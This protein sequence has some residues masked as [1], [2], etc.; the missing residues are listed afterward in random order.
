[1][2]YKSS[3]EQA[4][5]DFVLYA[6]DMIPADPV[7]GG[8]YI[9]RPS[10]QQ[11]TVKA[12]TASTIQHLGTFRKR[13]GFIGVSVVDG[14]IYTLSGTT[15]T[16]QVTTANLTTS[17]I[18]LSSTARVHCCSFNNTYVMNDGVNQPFTYDGTSGAASVV[19]LTNAPSKCF[20]KPTVYYG[21]LF[22]I[23]D[24]AASS[25]DRSKIVWSEEYAANT[26]YEAGGYLNV[27]TL[28]QAGSGALYAIVGTNPG[29]YYFRQDS[30]G[31]IH[32]AVTPAFTSSGVHEDVSAL[33]GTTCPDVLW[34]DR[35]IYFL[36]ARGR[37]WRFPETGTIEPLW[38]E[39]ADLYGGVDT[40]G[41]GVL[42]LGAYD[43]AKSNVTAFPW[44][45]GVVFGTW[46]TVDQPYN[47][48]FSHL[49]GLALCRIRGQAVS[50][51]AT[52]QIMG[53]VYDTTNTRLVLALGITTG[54]V[55]YANLC[56]T[57]SGNY[58]ETT[59][60]GGNRSLVLGA[61]GGVPD[62]VW[63][64][65][66]VGITAAIGATSAPR[67]GTVTV[68]IAT[69][70]SPFANFTAQASKTFPSSGTYQIQARREWGINQRLRWMAVNIVDSGGFEGW[71][72]DYVVV[73]GK[74]EIMESDKP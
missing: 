37:P 72:V 41:Q 3:P 20:G 10:D 50:G 57:I 38:K 36:D 22:F 70:E 42:I 8:A 67:T 48:L 40:P 35:Y 49:T 51:P 13:S 14:E 61:F 74:P 39:L 60:S 29:L 31:V 5:P 66:R 9:R 63:R 46:D 52:T 34:Y 64:F 24:V 43:P 23:K 16:R 62:V 32:G 45:D 2:R 21:K 17:S 18:T 28:E 15:W 69:T 68:R 26:G 25:A 30:I 53:T 56:P 44:V 65:S 71:G 59:D 12:A 27:W 11:T 54:S 33:V 1:M 19:K 55:A 6:Q 47:F 7:I 58:Y 4:Q 73:D